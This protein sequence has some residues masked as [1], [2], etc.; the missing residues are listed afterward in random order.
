MLNALL[1]A[2]GVYVGLTYAFGM[3]LA[4]RALLGHRLRRVIRGV[5]P[6]RL[7]RPLRAQRMK[8]EP[9]PPAPAGSLGYARRTAA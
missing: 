3:Y 7:V 8:P 5:S 9:S 2:L 4:A 1:I 6:R